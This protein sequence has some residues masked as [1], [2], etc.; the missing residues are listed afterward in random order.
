MSRAEDLIK[1]QRDE[2]EIDRLHK[3]LRETIRKHFLGIDKVV[4]DFSEEN[5]IELTEYIRY[6]ARN[7]GE[8]N[9]ALDVS[10]DKIKILFL[11]FTK[12]SNL[13]DANMILSYLESVEF[14]WHGTEYYMSNLCLRR[15]LND[16]KGHCKRAAKISNTELATNMLGD[17]YDIFFGDEFSQTAL[18]MFSYCLASVFTSVLNKGGISAPFF[19]QIAVDK[20]SIVYQILKE[21]VEICDVNSGIDAN[22]NRANSA[23][24][25]CNYTHQIYFPTQ[26]TVKDIDNLMYDFKDCPVL[27][28][29]HE[30]ERNYTALLREVSNIPTKKKAL[31]LRERFNLLPVFVCPAIKSSFDNVFNMDLTT[32]EVSPKYL[33]LIKKNK[34][35]LASWVL[36]LVTSIDRYQLQETELVDKRQIARNRSLISSVISPYINQVCQNH[37]KLMIDNA[38]NVG[39]LNYFFGRY[40]DTFRRLCTFPDD[41]KFEFF[42]PDNLPAQQDIREI[43]SILKTQSEKSLADLHHRYLPA[44]TAAGIK[45]RGAANLAKQVENHYRALKVYVRVIP[46]EVRADR[47]IFKLETLNETKDV[48]ISRTAKTVQRRLKK[49]EWF[50]VDLRNPTSI[51]LVVAEQALTDNSLIEMLNSGDFAESE[52]KIPYAMGFDDTGAMCIEDIVEFPHLLLGGATK[53]GKSTAMMSLLMSIA[54]K[55]RTGNVNVLILDLLGKD[56]SDFDV[57]KSQ[58]FLSTPIIT[59]PDAARKII[60]L[61]CQERTRRMKDPNLP[62]MPYIVCVIDEFP[63]LYSSISSKEYAEQIKEAMNELLSSSRHTKIHLVLAAQNPGKGDIVGSIANITARIALKCAH[64]QNSVTIL[65]RAGAE[66]LVGRGQMIFDSIFERG[67]VLQGSYI[68][69]EDMTM[70]L[71]EIEKTFEQQNKYPFKIGSLDTASDPIER[72]SGLPGFSQSPQGQSYDEKLAEAIMW[73]LPQRQ[74][75]NSR[76]QAKLQVGNNRANRLLSRMEDWGLI[77]RLHGNLGWE[78]VPKCFE[79][80]PITVIN[81]LNESGV[82][83]AEIR[84]VFQGDS[85]SQVNDEFRQ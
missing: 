73:T 84:S 61:L 2:E 53:S 1:N 76:L 68:S 69:F 14:G 6:F 24:G 50:R 57:F 36:E 59:E 19:L 71:T 79:D 40:L 31:D 48:D 37:P 75:A 52:L 10:T 72:N 11:L 4:E 15:F 78:T 49:Y 54:Y 46:T 3:F 28:V 45:D 85:D 80:I 17:F 41:E 43:V 77:H 66:K 22:C 67:R 12:L 63:R 70:L 55:H 42:E 26:S 44:P 16:P 33:A 60:L 27:I 7:H 5:I 34:Q 56:Q 47:Y 23:H 35:M 82:T 83:E 8:E 81:Y 62:D 58:P 51:N 38:K 74:V 18:F 25:K 32:F 20:S 29:G 21:I 39:F 65:G 30:N 9:L 64:Y 13:N